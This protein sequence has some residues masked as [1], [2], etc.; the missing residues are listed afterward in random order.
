MQEEELSTRKPRFPLWLWNSDSLDQTPSIN[1][2]DIA[3]S[4]NNFPSSKAPPAHT[5]PSS[6]NTFLGI[7]THIK[8]PTHYFP[9]LSS[10][11]PFTVSALDP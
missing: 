6:K 4:S 5:F 9:L 1:L 3:S 8:I 2:C 7:A 11:S 10:V